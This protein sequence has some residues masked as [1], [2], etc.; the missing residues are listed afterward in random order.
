VNLFARFPLILVGFVWGVRA[1]GEVKV[2]VAHRDPSEATADSQF[3]ELVV[4][5]KGDAAEKGRFSIIEGSVDPNSGGIE[6]LNDGKLPAGE[7]EPRANFFFGPGTDGGRVLLDLGETTVLRQLNSYSWHA[8]A[9]APQVYRVFA[10]TGVGASFNPKPKRPLNPA[11]VG[12][13]FLAAIDT[14]SSSE[15]LGGQYGVHIFDPQGTLGSFRYLL[16]DVEKTENDDPFGE[17]F[18]SEI[19]VVDGSGGQPIITEPR[20]LLREKVITVEGRHQII[21]DT[22]EAPDLTEWAK[23]ELAPLV[24]EWYPRIVAFLPGDGFQA[25]AKVSI[26]FKEMDGV[27]ATGGAKVECAAKWFRE[28]LQGEAR[29]AVI[30]ELVHVVQHYGSRTVNNPHPTENPGWLV[31][32]IADYVRWYRYEATPAGAQISADALENVRYDDSYRPSANFLNWVSLKYSPKIVPA[33]NSAMREGRYSPQIWVNLTG[34]S[35]DALG[36]EWKQALAS[37]LGL[38]DVKSKAQTK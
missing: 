3:D 38:P 19:D 1:A 14:H 2:S 9:R 12:W 22:T 32:G 27:A 18:F 31:E 13:T 10:S 25:P 35:V 30:H 4:P 36:A 5:L 26:H 34:K 11:E 23:R 15:A 16:F 7:D 21:L 28:N 24:R 20:R 6:V 17:T 33:L 37:N 29:G 8:G